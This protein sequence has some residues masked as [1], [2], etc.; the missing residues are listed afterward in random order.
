MNLELDSI[1]NDQGLLRKFK[2]LSTIFV[3]TI[4]DIHP[5]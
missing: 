1:D 3:I 5:Q 2:N 4:T